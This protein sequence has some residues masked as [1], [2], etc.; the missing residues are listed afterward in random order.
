MS[1][2]R[3]AALRQRSMAAKEDFKVIHHRAILGVDGHLKRNGFVRVVDIGTRTAHGEVDAVVN[4]EFGWICFPNA[5]IPHI[6]F[7]G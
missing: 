7:I 6:R 3:S 5:G 1:P 4:I 2:S